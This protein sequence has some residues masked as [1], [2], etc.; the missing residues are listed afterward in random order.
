[1]NH[2]GSLHRHNTDWLSAGAVAYLATPN[3][4][5]FFGWFRFPLAFGLALAVI[6]LACSPATGSHFHPRHRAIEVALIGLSGLAWAVFSGGS[7]FLHADHDWVVRDAVL[8]DLVRQGWPVLYLT[9]GGEFGILRSAIG[10]FL[11]AALYGKALGSA[12]L[13]FA[14]YAWTALGCILFLMLLPLSKRS[15]ARLLLALLVIVAFSGMDFLGGLIATQ[16]LPIFPFRLEWWVPLSYP[17]MTGH[18]TWAPNHCLPAWVG[19]ALLIRHR[20][21][22]EQLTD[23]MIVTLPLTLIW[24]PFAIVGLLPLTIVI[25]WRLLLKRAFW[26][27]HYRTLLA[28]SLITLTVTAFLL[29]DGTQN[30]ALSSTLTTRG[31]GIARQSVAISD[32]ALFILLEFGLLGL[33]LTR[34][35][36]ADRSLFLVSIGILLALPFLHLGPSNDLLIRSSAPAL[37]VLLVCTLSCLGLLVDKQNVA[38]QQAGRKLIICTLLV[39]GAVTPVHEFARALLRPAQA[40]SYERTLAS[41]Q[42]GH[43]PA[44]YVGNFPR[45]LGPFLFRSSPPARP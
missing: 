17:S 44:H 13:P 27:T 14:V 5:F 32:I 25:C 31:D 19:T 15:P 38:P 2:F 33:C 8:G 1:M 45:T 22:P 3:L 21:D 18:L 41:T 37:V 12:T 10:F 29:I 7:H 35:M 42:A 23:W 20:H 40:P 24:S 39:L 4:I 6:Y 36:G 26:K 16:S 28:A 11:P 30:I 43:F 9:D 34:A